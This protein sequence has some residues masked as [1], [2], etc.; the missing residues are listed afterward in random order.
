MKAFQQ[1]YQKEFQELEE[2]ALIFLRQPPSEQKDEIVVVLWHFPAFGD[3]RSWSLIK[4]S[5]AGLLREA[6]WRRLADVNRFHDPLQGLA[7][8]LSTQPTIE[9]KDERLGSDLLK[10][11]NDGLDELAKQIF[12]M[13]KSNAI[14]LDGEIF[15]VHCERLNPETAEWWCNGPSEWKRLIEWATE[16]RGLLAKCCAITTPRSMEL[17][18][19]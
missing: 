6:T 14:G 13:P 10:V 12:V 2:R 7:K 15:G 9:I 5:N 17:S 4:K 16:T 8:G 18:S 11:V 3:F 19:I 1:T